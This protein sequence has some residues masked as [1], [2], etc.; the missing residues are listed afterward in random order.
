MIN[1]FSTCKSCRNSHSMCWY[2]K[3][4][5][6]CL[7][8]LIFSE[9]VDLWIHHCAITPLQSLLTCGRYLICGA[10]T[11]LLHPFKKEGMVLTTQGWHQ[12]PHPSSLF[13]FSSS[14]PCRLSNQILMGRT[15]GKTNILL[16]LFS[17]PFQ[18]VQLERD[19]I[20]VEDKSLSLLRVGCGM[21]ETVLY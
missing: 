9:K 18:A 15:L 3:T 11:A 8:N 7:A 4:T 20:L 14:F 1:V 6:N 12:E 13:Y 2:V 5:K 19:T 17:C 21:K 16:M 10:T